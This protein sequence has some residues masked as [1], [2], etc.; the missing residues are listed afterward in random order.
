MNKHQRK[1]TRAL[2]RYKRNSMG[3]V[4]HGFKLTDSLKT[5]RK[6]FRMEYKLVP[7]LFK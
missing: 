5:V 1:I 7:E 4:I 2:K 3:K 6:M